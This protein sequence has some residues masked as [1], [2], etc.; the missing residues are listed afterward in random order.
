MRSILFKLLVPVAFLSVNSSLTYADLF[1]ASTGLTAGNT[2]LDMQVN[3]LT[4]KVSLTMSGDAHKWFGF[5]FDASTMDVGPYAIV[6][7]GDGN[8]FEQDL[9]DRSPGSRVT[10]DT[11]GFKVL[12][13]TVENN[14]RTVVVERNIQQ[15]PATYSIASEVLNTLNPFSFPQSGGG[16][17]MIW[18]KG[19]AAHFAFHDVAGELHVNFEL[20]P[21]SEAVSVPLM[22]GLF[23]LIFLLAGSVFGYLSLNK[24]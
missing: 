4:G 12:S 14:L 17:E 11:A 15:D 7:Q 2:Q 6:A 13:N 19:F 1:T 10:S 3:T 5:G 20:Q 22:P 18:A 21:E 9:A 23:T 8:V 16:L 24:R